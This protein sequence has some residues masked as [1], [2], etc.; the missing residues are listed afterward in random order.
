MKVKVKKSKMVRRYLFLRNKKNLSETD[1][2][3]SKSAMLT[4]SMKTIFI[5][6]AGSYMLMNS[7]ILKRENFSVTNIKILYLERLSIN[8]RCYG[9]ERVYC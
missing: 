9:N 8:S 2:S 5:N 1:A 7:T 3:D 6:L 4:F